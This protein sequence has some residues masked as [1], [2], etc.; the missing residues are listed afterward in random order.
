MSE[1]TIDYETVFGISEEQFEEI[2]KRALEKAKN[3]RHIWRQRGHKLVCTSCEYQHSFYIGKNKVMVGEREN[4][5]PI[6][7]DL[8]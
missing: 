5:E 6:L 2:R 3:T 4:G 1:K 8:N 7:E